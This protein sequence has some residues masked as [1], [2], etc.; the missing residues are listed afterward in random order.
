MYDCTAREQSHTSRVHGVPKKQVLFIVA[1]SATGINTGVAPLGKWNQ[2]FLDGQR[3]HPSQ[4][5]EGASCLVI[6]AC[7]C[8]REEEGEGEGS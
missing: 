4:E 8:G 5:V 3:G 1:S 7:M 2:R 6:S